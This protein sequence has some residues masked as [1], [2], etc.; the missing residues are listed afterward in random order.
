MGLDPSS[1]LVVIAIVT[2]ALETG[3]DAAGH[4]TIAQP[5]V[6]DDFPYVVRGTTVA[7]G[8]AIDGYSCSSADESGGEVVYA[9]TLPAAARV[10]AWVEGD[11]GDGGEVDIDVHILRDLAMTDTRATNC[12]ARDNVIAE[13]ELEAG[14]HYVVVDT[15]RGDSHAGPYVLHLEAIGDAWIERQLAEGVVWRARRYANLDGG[16]QVVGELVAD[17]SVAGLQIR[18][19]PATGCQTIGSLGRAA[20]AV[21][22]VNGGYFSTASGAGCAPVSLLRH[23]GE[24]LATN[25]SSS[26]RGAFGLDASGQPLIATTAPG[27]DWPAAAEAHGGGPVLVVGGQARQGRAAWASEGFSSTSFLGTNPRTLAGMEGPSGPIHLVVVDGRRASA[28]GMSL[29]DLA[30][31]AASPELGL[32]DAVNLDGGGSSTLWVAG[33]TPSGVVNYPSDAGSIEQSTH[34]GSRGVSGGLFVF[35]PPYNHPPRFQTQPPTT[36]MVGAP[37]R[38]QAEAID[39]DV[40]ADDRVL[41]SLTTAPGGMIV[42][43]ELGVVSWTPEA[44]APATATVTL[45]ATDSRGA[46]SAQ[47]YRIAV[48][49]GTGVDGGVASDGGAADGSVLQPDDAGRREDGA[50]DGQGTRPDGDG[51]AGAAGGCMLSERRPPRRAA[52]TPLIVLVAALLLARRSGR[53]RRQ[54]RNRD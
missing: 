22:G 37:Y 41:F 43:A 45:V 19:L 16:P 54:R 38:Y 7:A 33:A 23:Q 11:G 44:G 8:H 53:Q 26:P 31:F 48:V 4:G 1:S 5:F 20:G 10:T 39:I 42:D 17:P 50:A 36:A 3:A 9:F 12:A 34:P 51:D 28:A 15:Y 32:L 35:A 52:A 6:V 2:V 25:D 30:A 46:A 21:A 24:L 18:A 29:D 47:A 27:A 49:G 13:A 40:A 14:T